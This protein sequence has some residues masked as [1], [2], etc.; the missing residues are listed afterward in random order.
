MHIYVYLVDQLLSEEL[1][2]SNL[3]SINQ[4]AKISQSSLRYSSVKANG[5]LLDDVFSLR[6][7]AYIEDGSIE[8][9]NTQRFFDEYDHLP[10]C[11][12]F[13]T[14][15][16]EELIG[17]IRACQYIPNRHEDVPVMEIFKKEIEEAI[18]LNKSFV[19]SNKFVI[20]P[21]FQ[22]KG[23]MRARFHLVNNMLT[24]L[25]SSSMYS[26]HC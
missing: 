18:G 22:R 15:L 10:N 9:N 16:D 6:Y 12:S 4:K 8:K 1:M 13:L 20:A 2:N 14:Y 3:V 25:T 24:T 7:N 11:Q 5:R 19:E 17:S 23:G 26:S 21:E